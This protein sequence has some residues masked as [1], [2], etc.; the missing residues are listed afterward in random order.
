MS[1]SF[2]KN[3]LLRLLILGLLIVGFFV[4]DIINNTD[5]SYNDNYTEDDINNITQKNFFVKKMEAFFSRVH[6]GHSSACELD[7]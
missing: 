1:W 2:I 5:Q 7:S 4:T 6:N 3:N